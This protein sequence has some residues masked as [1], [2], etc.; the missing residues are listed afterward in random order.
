MEVERLEGESG[1]RAA[2]AEALER[3]WVAEG[4]GAERLVEVNGVPVAEAAQPETFM[5]PTVMGTPKKRRTS[6]GA[7]SG[8]SVG[9]FEWI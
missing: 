9:T 1:L 5:A 6:G 7:E 4:E 2:E 8:Y 3:P